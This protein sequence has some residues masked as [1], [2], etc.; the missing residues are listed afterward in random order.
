MV[1]LYYNADNGMTYKAE[2]PQSVE[3]EEVSFW[4]I[5]PGDSRWVIFP[6]KLSK[7]SSIGRNLRKH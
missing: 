3:F 4:T 7:M 5:K 1:K 6:L 2:E